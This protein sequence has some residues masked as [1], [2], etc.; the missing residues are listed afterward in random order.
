[1]TSSPIHLLLYLWWE[2]WELWERSIV[3]RTLGAVTDAVDSPSWNSAVASRYPGGG[4]WEL[5]ACRAMAEAI[6]VITADME[7]FRQI[8]LSSAE[9]LAEAARNGVKIAD[10]AQLQIRA[11]LEGFGSGLANSED[12][13]T[14]DG[15]R[16]IQDNCRQ[17]GELSSVLIDVA[18]ALAEFERWTAGASR[19]GSAQPRPRGS[20]ATPKWRR[21]PAPPAALLG[22]IDACLEHLR[23]A[24][25]TLSG[26][27]LSCAQPWERLLVD[28]RE[29]IVSS[30]EVLVPRWVSIRYCYP[31]AVDDNDAHHI[32][33]VHPDLAPR[34]N[35]LG[36]SPADVERISRGGTSSEPPLRCRL[37]E[38]CAFAFGE[39]QFI[40]GKPTPLTLT[41]F[42]QGSGSG[43]NGGVKV[44][45]PEL[46]II[47]ARRSA[48][49]G[50]EEGDRL[51][52]WI[53]L[54]R[55]GNHCLCVERTA[56]VEEAPPH[57][58][59]RAFRTGTPF[60]SG[61][62]VCLAKA[63]ACSAT[64]A[65]RAPLQPADKG[66]TLVWDSLHAFARDAIRATAN[67]IWFEHQEDR[68]GEQARATGPANIARF[69]QGNPHEIL[70]VQTDGPLGERPEEV[71]DVL[72]RTV[73]GRVL[74]RSV[75]RLA[76]TLEEWVRFPP[77][78]QT[79]Q[80][81][82]TSTVTSLP[83]LG[84]AGDWLIHTGDTSVLGIVAVPSWLSNA[85]IEVAQ[86]AG[87]WSPLLRLCNNRLGEALDAAREKNV[88]ADASETL[89]NVEL[90]VRTHP[91]QVRSEE[92]CQSPTHQRLLD[93][94]LKMAGV[95][96]LQDELET[97]LVAAERLIDWSAELARK[98]AERAQGIFL[99]AI[100]VFGVFSLVDFL[101]LA[102]TT[103]FNRRTGSWEDWLVL[104]L[105]VGAVVVGGLVLNYSYWG[106]TALYRRFIKRVGELTRGWTGKRRRP[107]KP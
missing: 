71:A 60:V 72:D 32:Q 42:W 43:S 91:L 47:D 36:G 30:G 105:F 88:D 92:L 67:A 28:I 63:P 106:S 20:G 74:V 85:Y 57:V 90:R 18:Q 75:H 46:E 16:Y 93:L 107:R 64:Q 62:M 100:G 66:H 38:E 87:S 11:V 99:C 70:I 79:E 59:Y 50:E 41:A 54:N 17:L 103:R 14:R 31:F 15:L 80:E 89:R 61:E 65:S 19:R 12:V 44:D 34:S 13:L 8:N 35:S 39:G 52:A 7:V 40:V 77:S 81:S 22:K 95:N 9:G 51:R 55:L 45:L 24:Q 49:S 98:K 10:S 104:A 78:H 102:N 3:Y 25:R 1:M 84:F 101:T 2:C 21:R 33:K 68:S 97:Q 76:S 48:E 37:M 56:A 73:G 27:T 4:A 53:E 29:L 6:R 82:A 94:L 26:Y 5:P 86:F 23:R 96:R 83:E 69:V 58:L